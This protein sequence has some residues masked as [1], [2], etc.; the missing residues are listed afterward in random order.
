MKRQWSRVGSTGA[1]AART[2]RRPGAQSRHCAAAARS[3]SLAPSSARARARARC[4]PL[5]AAAAIKAARL[6]NGRGGAA[7][8]CEI[9]AM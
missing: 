4:A 1:K 5:A 9:A 2:R 3:S 6:P 8:R 7:I